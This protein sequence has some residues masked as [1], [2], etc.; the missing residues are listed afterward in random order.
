MPE[1]PIEIVETVPARA[2]LAGNPSDGYGGAVLAV[3]VRAVGARVV[4]RP[5]AQIGVG[6]QR[7]AS[8]DDVRAAVRERRVSGLAALAAAAVDAF[9]TH[10]APPVPCE[11]DVSTTIPRSVG[12]AGSSAVVIG[13]LR[14]LARISGRATLPP[15]ELAAIALAAEVDGLG[16]A[17]G[18]QDRVVQCRDSPTHMEFGSGEHEPVEPA[19]PF[20]LLVAYRPGASTPSGATHGPLRERFDRGDRDVRSAMA[21]L[22]GEARRATAALRRGDTA[23]LGSAMDRSFDIRRSVV[24]LDPAHV[25][26]VER[27]RANGVA[28]NYS[29][30]GGSITVLAPEGSAGARARS[31]LAEID[32]RFLDVMVR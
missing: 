23:T 24:P 3:P 18:L 8:P 27:A 5:A 22:A 30:S 13:V 21:S 12:L 25:E 10:V 11:L 20:H 26:M 17:A 32:C 4:A 9:A 1:L 28:A 2:A 15:D 31:A 7:F 29:G 19:T 14:A 6:G 16:I